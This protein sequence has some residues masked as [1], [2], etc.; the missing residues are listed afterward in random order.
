MT[1]YYRS[2]EIPIAQ[3]IYETLKKEI[4]RGDY[5]PGARLPSESEL[6]HAY[7]VQRDTARCALKKLVDE[8]LIF[9]R[10]GRGSFVS[11]D[12]GRVTIIID[13]AHLNDPVIAHLL[14]GGGVLSSESARRK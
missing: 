5:A 8:G 4:E 12:D 6:S 13:R 3:I 2:R 11:G 7:G 10:P 1:A 9:K 14:A